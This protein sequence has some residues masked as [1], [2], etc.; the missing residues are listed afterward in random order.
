MYSIYLIT[1]LVTKLTLNNSK[2]TSL[3]ALRGTF[4]K[5]IH[6]WK[7]GR[8]ETF[9]VSV[10]GNIRNVSSMLLEISNST[11]WLEKLIES[12]FYSVLRVEPVEDLLSFPQ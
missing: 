9:E 8:R 12:N 6:K 2:T 5:T 11:D 10:Q 1:I 3:N 7:G 4:P